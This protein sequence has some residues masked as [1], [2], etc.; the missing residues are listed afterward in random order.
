MGTHQKRL[1]SFFTRN[2]LPRGKEKNTSSSSLPVE[3]PQS[4]PEDDNPLPSS[5]IKSPAPSS[6]VENP[7]FCS[8][9][10]DLGLCRPIW[11][12]ATN[13]KDEIRR[14]Y[15]RS[16]P[17][18]PV[19]PKYPPSRSKSHSRHFQSKWYSE[20]P[21]LE[22]SK[23]KDRAY[24]FYC[25]IFLEESNTH[26]GH[27]AF[28]TIGFKNWNKVKGKY[29]SFLKHIGD[30]PNSQHYNVM[31][32]CDTLMNHSV[33]ID[34]AMQKQSVDQIEKNMLRVKTSIDVVRF[35]SFQG[36][37]FRGHDEKIDSKNCGNFI[38]LI[39]HATSYNEEVAGVVLENAP[40]NAKYTSPEVQ[41]E[42]LHV[43]AKKVRKKNS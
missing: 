1:D 7:T 4:P 39:K 14:A 36:I 38:E 13:M 25:Y 27:D 29:C 41:K 8:I 23:T 6:T 10:H 15:L 24:C 37:S 19:L 34:K 16:G 42:I 31:R 20:F 11:K 35:L 18:Q 30:I 26:N 32:F 5:T 40:G 9:E 43:F 2:V 12:Y 22:Y 21:W 33:H 28:T 3:K 17:H